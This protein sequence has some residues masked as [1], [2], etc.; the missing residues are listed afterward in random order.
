MGLFH[1]PKVGEAPI[2]HMYKYRRLDARWNFENRDQ[3]GL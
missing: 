2:L 3:M 1:I